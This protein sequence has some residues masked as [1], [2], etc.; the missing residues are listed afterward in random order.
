MKIV[1]TGGAGFIGS[2]LVK[3]LLDKKYEIIVVDNFSTGRQ[4]NV[5]E[6]KNKIKIVKADISRKGSWTKYFKNVKAV[7]HLAALA[8][9]VPSIQ[10]PEKYFESNVLGTKNVLNTCILNKIPKII[11]SASSSCYGIPSKYPT[12]E[13][14]KID[15]RYPYALTKRIGEEMILHYSRIYNIRALS[16]RLFNV[17]GTKSR[18]SGTYG[19]MFGVFL[20]Q[21]IECK[22]L[23]VVGN[24]KQ[25]RDFTY[26]SDIVDV[27]YKCLFYKGKI[28]IFNVGT[29][30]P[31]S[32]NKIVEI[33]K[34]K[35]IKI[36]KRP[37]EPDITHA[38]I[39]LVKKELNWRPKIT[40]EKG[41]SLILKEIDY[42]KKAPLWTP[43]KIKKATVDW[44]RYIK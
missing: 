18:T 17:Y 35:K 20:K 14:E 22:P 29:G 39:N 9:I 12:T 37:G 33:L 36:P 34:C 4:S 44:F 19:A 16:L 31:V 38:N 43:N 6:F 13:N 23:T 26:V 7:F 30:K 5:K 24:G 15:P 32:V 21:K 2:H 40:I 11:Y 27:F 3:K 10:N 1:I 8:D 41:V 28:N 42:W 25:K